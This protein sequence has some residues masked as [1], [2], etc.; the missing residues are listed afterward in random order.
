MV[1]HLVGLPLH[2][3]LR[4]DPSGLRHLLPGLEPPH[5]SLWL[6]RHKSLRKR[7]FLLFLSAL[8]G[9]EDTL[10]FT[11]ESF[12]ST[13]LTSHLLGRVS[14]SPV[15]VALHVVA[16]DDEFARL[17]GDGRPELVLTAAEFLAN[18]L[19]L[20]RVV[21]TPLLLQE[22]EAL[23]LPLHFALAGTEAE[24]LAVRGLGLVPKR[25][26]LL[27]GQGA[28][29]D[30]AAPGRVIL[31]DVLLPQVVVCLVFSHTDYSLDDCEG[32]KRPGP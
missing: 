3:V 24:E 19:G 11:L 21:L 9:T 14:V 15:M 32:P 2:L 10:Q 26:G 29:V 31:A 8:D 7:L 16:G 12:E 6:V 1:I 22:F 30:D 28:A 13:L 20:G 17:T 5:F 27:G 18:E 4:D 25:L 23:G